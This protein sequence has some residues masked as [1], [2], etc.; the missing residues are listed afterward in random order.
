MELWYVGQY[1]GE[2]SWEFQ[3]VFD[4]KQK[5]IDACVM[6]NFFIQSIT[7]NEPLPT[8][9]CDSTGYYPLIEDENHT[10]IN[11]RYEGYIGETI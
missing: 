2:S 9:T 10:I 11:P 4:S 3:G 6:E 5:A 8:Q 7:L 1:M